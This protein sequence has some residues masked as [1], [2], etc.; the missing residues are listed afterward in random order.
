MILSHLENIILIAIVDLASNLVVFFLE[1]PTTL[2]NC[3]SQKAR[4]PSF[5][6]ALI[7]ISFRLKKFA[8]WSSFCSRLAGRS[9]GDSINGCGTTTLRASF[10]S[11]IYGK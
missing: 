2:I 5:F 8:A 11:R 1:I 10:E 4:F 7:Q 3:S 6:T 9:C